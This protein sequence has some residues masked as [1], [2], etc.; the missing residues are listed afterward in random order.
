MLGYVLLIVKKCQHEGHQLLQHKVECDDNVIIDADLTQ[1]FWANVVPMAKCWLC[2]T[3]WEQ[4][5]MMKHKMC[6]S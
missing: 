1:E 6:L 2:L 3:L 5:H 4:T